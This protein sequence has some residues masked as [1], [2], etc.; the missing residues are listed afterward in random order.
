MAQEYNGR[1]TTAGATRSREGLSQ[2]EVRL[3]ALLRQIHWGEVRTIIREG[4]ITLIQ[5]TDSYKFD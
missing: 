5:K 4:E 3:I 2:R 1:Q